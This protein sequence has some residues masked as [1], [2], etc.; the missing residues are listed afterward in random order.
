MSLSRHFL[1]KEELMQIIENKYFGKNYSIEYQYLQEIV[2]NA[3]TYWDVEF[4]GFN[5]F[6]SKILERYLKKGE[7]CNNIIDFI[8]KLDEAL[9]YSRQEFDSD[10][11]QM[12]MIKCKPSAANSLEEDLL[13]AII[14]FY[15]R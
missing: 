4:I 10:F 14:L 6:L 9:L 11:I 13:Q 15:E 8:Y 2:D 3:S 5:Y 7:N 1:S 12:L